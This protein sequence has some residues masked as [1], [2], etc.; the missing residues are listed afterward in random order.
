[1]EIGVR[2]AE[3]Y[4]LLG[5]FLWVLQISVIFA[6]LLSEKEQATERGWLAVVQFPSWLA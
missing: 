4:V 1:M 5:I 3:Q 6:C 2:A